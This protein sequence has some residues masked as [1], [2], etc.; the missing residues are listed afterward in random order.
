MRLASILAAS[1]L[2]LAPAPALA[3]QEFV[4][5]DAGFAVSLPEGWEAT[6]GEKDGRYIVMASEYLGEPGSANCVIQARPEEGLAEIDEDVMREVVRK[7][8]AAQ[9]FT[10]SDPAVSVVDQN[11]YRAG[12]AQADVTDMDLVLVMRMMLIHTPRFAY[13]LT[14]GFTQENAASEVPI[15][16]ALEQSFRLLP[17]D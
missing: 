11:G 16:E 10:L 8:S 6:S 15:V 13:M 3:Q 14:C 1:T 9:S 7:A 2:V 5:E 4:L 17:G 12:L